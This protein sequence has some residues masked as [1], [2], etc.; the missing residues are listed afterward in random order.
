MKSAGSINECS[1]GIDGDRAFEDDL[2]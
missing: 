2:L 1:H